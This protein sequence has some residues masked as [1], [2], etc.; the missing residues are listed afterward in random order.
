[1]TTNNDNLVSAFREMVAVVSANAGAGRGGASATTPNNHQSDSGGMGRGGQ[2]RGR[3]QGGVRGG[4]SMFLHVS[5]AFNKLA[6]LQYIFRLFTRRDG[7]GRPKAGDCGVRSGVSVNCPRS[8]KRME[9]E[10]VDRNR[11]S[12]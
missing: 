6:L 9:V 11:H 10:A 5:L 7:N 12:R 2:G 3:G 4:C 1:M 8:R